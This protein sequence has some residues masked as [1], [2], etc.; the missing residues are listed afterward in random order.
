MY[1]KV[2]KINVLKYTYLT[3]L[4]FSAQVLAWQPALKKIK[5][6][7][8][9]LSDLSMLLIAEKGIRCGICH[10]VYQSPETN[11]KYMKDYNPNK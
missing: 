8:E 3:L 5:V 4:L 1:L 6:E 10:S 7:L 2:S 9:L 11:N